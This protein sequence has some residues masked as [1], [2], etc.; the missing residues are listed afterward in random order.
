MNIT[1]LLQAVLKGAT[2]PPPNM[3]GD[4]P[5]HGGGA[6]GQPPLVPGLEIP[7]EQGGGMPR[8]P[9]GSGAPQQPMGGGLDDI[10][11][12]ILGGTTQPPTGRNRP[13]QPMGGGG[14]GDILGAVLGGGGVNAADNSFLAPLVDQ[15][16]N[17]L[18]LPPALA[19]V[20]VSFAVT[21]MLAA[22][23]SGGTHGNFAVNHLMEHLNSDEGVPKDFAH[24]SGIAAEL[25]Q[26]TGLDTDTA[27]QALQTV[28]NAMGRQVGEGEGAAKGDAP[29]VL[30]RMK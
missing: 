3:T 8:P 24:S 12:A 9:L 6:P 5:S 13:Q 10:L 17:K 4:Q 2:N 7:D 30:G 29:T 1:D 20:V 22:H 11:G 19:Q 23:A 28:Y 26:S 21:K 25:A 16:A 15:L 14:M 27:A 18:G